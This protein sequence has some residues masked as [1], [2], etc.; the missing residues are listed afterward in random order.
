T[1]AP[2]ARTPRWS[3]AANAFR[4]RDADSGPPPWVRVYRRLFLSMPKQKLSC[5]DPL[6]IL[7]CAIIFCLSVFLSFYFLLFYFLAT[8]G[9]L[10]GGP[11]FN[12][13]E[14]SVISTV[15]GTPSTADTRSRTRPASSASPPR[16]ASGL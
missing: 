11:S 2:N 9:I 7:S 1:T 12:S 5:L 16:N 4:H 13:S 3:T 14:F 10:C 6:H 15:T 8:R